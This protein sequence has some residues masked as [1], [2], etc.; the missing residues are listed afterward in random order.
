MNIRIFCKSNTQRDLTLTCVQ[1]DGWEDLGI[2]LFDCGAD[3]TNISEEWVKEITNMG[4]RV[5]Q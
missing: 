3:I 4:I 5:E 2:T 1:A